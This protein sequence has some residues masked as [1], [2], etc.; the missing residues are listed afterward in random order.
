MK[1]EIDPR[2]RP[3]PARP[4]VPGP[5][6]GGPCLRR[7]NRYTEPVSQLAVRPGSPGDKPAVVEIQSLCPQAA[8]WPEDA[9]D[10]ILTG[11]RPEKCLVAELDESVI[12]FLL[13]RLTAPDECEILN[14]AVDPSHRRAGAGRGLVDWLVSR[15]AADVRLEVREGNESAKAFYHAQ[16]FVATGRR[17][18]YYRYPVEDAVLMVRKAG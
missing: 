2:E 6:P 10:E 18:A 12:G 5:G 3:Q 8:A 7:R 16:G 4:S 13:Y 14:L 15:H 11:G 9:Y 1:R 17:T